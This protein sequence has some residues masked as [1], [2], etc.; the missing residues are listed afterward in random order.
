M[1]AAAIF[2]PI[3]ETFV[4][5]YFLI[6]LTIS[7]TKLVIKRGSTILAILIPAGIGG[8]YNIS[9]SNFDYYLSPQ[10]PALF[11]SINP[12]YFYNQKKR[13]LE[14]KNTNL[15]S[16]SYFGLKV[17]YA[18]KSISSEV[19]SDKVLLYNIHWGVQ[20][21]IGKNTLLNAFAGIGYGDRIDSK[22]G[23]PYPALGIKLSYI[24]FAKD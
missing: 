15:N 22:F 7:L 19:F 23:T 4:F 16:G 2:A 14:G 5:Q 12:K 18:S 24:P 11:V 9:E 1:F 13:V 17:K 8:Y 21:Q 20:R 3:V 6:S 10:K